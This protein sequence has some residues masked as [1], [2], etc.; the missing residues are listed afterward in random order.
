MRRSDIAE[1]WMRPQLDECAEGL[2][3]HH[4]AL[5]PVTLLEPRGERLPR[6]LLAGAHRQGD[7]LLVLRLVGRVWVRRLDAKHLHLD[8]VADVHHLARMPHPDVR[9]LGHRHEP[10]DAA[11]IDEHAE[12]PDAG[13]PALQHLA[14]GEALA[15]LGSERLLLVLEQRAAAQHHVLL[16]HLGDPEPQPLADVLVRLVH[17]AQVHLAQRNEGPSVADGDL[18]AT[19]VHREDQALHRHTARPRLGEHRQRRRA[20]A[21]GAAEDDALGAGLDDVCLHRV[22]HAEAEDAL[23]V[24]ELAEVDH[25]LGAAAERE[26]C[27]VRAELE[28]GAGDPLA[29]ARHL[30]V[31]PTLLLR[32][33][34]VH[35]GERLVLGD[36]LVERASRS[37]RRRRRRRSG[38]GSGSGARDGLGRRGALGRGRGGLRGLGGGRSVG[39]AGLDDTARPAHHHHRA[40]GLPALRLAGL[41]AR[42]LGRRRLGGRGGRRLVAAAIALRSV[43]LVSPTARGD[44]KHHVPEGGPRLPGPEALV[45]ALLIVTHLDAP[46]C[47]RTGPA[48]PT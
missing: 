6:I 10:L 2:Q 13:D 48:P 30:A 27:G 33:R 32:V 1:M 8:G 38:S 41:A 11:E 15:G 45:R 20:L 31:S 44:A 26:E 7:A 18:E 14:P 46:R 16:T 39:T 9:Q 4:L 43:L 12:V 21:Q 34:L 19:L 35:L 25:R 17:E 29:D 22:A 40:L 5:E 24:L 36:L 28:D 3:A 42:G 37:R 47:S 23:V